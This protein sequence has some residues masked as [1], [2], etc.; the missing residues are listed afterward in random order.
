LDKERD[1]TFD[2]LNKTNLVESY[3]LTGFVDIKQ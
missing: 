2:E 1:Y 3:I